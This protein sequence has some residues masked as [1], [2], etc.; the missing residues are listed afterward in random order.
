MYRYIASKIYACTD[1]SL[2]FSISYESGISFSG[3]DTELFCATTL[4]PRFLGDTGG[5]ATGVVG[6]VEDAKHSARS[7]CE[8]TLEGGADP[9]IIRFNTTK[10][11]DIR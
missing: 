8:P 2:L 7:E 11:I 5:V 9:A 4:L 10:T 1:I 6:A 3:T